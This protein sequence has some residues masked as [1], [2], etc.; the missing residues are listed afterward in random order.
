VK[1]SKQANQDSIWGYIPAPD[2]SVSP[3]Y[4]NYTIRPR[5]END[6]PFN[7]L[8]LLPIILLLIHPFLSRYSRRTRRACQNVSSIKGINLEVTSVVIRKLS[9]KDAIRYARAPVIGRVIIVKGKPIKAFN[10]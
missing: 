9:I 1:A 2:V 3:R 4:P 6:A 7:L 8:P 5:R 10:R